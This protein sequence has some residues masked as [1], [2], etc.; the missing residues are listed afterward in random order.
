MSRAAALRPAAAALALLLVPVAGCATT[1]EAGP[2][3]RSSADMQ[4]QLFKLQKDTARILALL[5]ES[6]SA[7]AGEAQSAC[8]EVATRLADIEQRMSAIEEQLLATQSRIDDAVTEV[9]SLRRSV[10]YAFARQGSGPEPAAAPAGQLPPAGSSPA[11]QPAAAGTPADTA[12]AAPAPPTSPEELF[13]AAYADFSRG[14]YDLAL[15]EFEQALR[16]DPDGPLAATCQFFIGET[17]MA[18]NRYQDAVAA[19]DQL[20]SA[21]PGSQRVRTARLK[22]GIAL[23]ES[24]RTVEAVQ[25]LQDLINEAP[26]S[27]EAK[28]AEEYLRRKGIEP[29]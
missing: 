1:L 17:L 20:I 13:N 29:N 5:E 15:G 8:A 2:A 21:W 11:G 7:G 25:A 27:D 12:G 18:M 16:A 19:F 3:P 10:P 6:G 4:S 23:F 28:I 24:H 26:G 22:R 9:R 14:N